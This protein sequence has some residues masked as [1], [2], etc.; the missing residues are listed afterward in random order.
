MQ[1]PHSQLEYFQ[2]SHAAVQADDIIQKLI[3]QKS[4]LVR[5]LT[6]FYWHLF[7][8]RRKMLRMDQRGQSSLDFPDF[9]KNSQ[10][11]ATS[12]HFTKVMQKKIMQIVEESEV[13]M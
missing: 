3:G 5:G 12:F 6:D 4:Y 9:K 11:L 8:I 1:I 10:P 13:G 7:R 2:L